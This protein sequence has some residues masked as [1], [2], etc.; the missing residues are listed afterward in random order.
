LSN[1][2]Q[3]AANTSK[4]RLETAMG[5]LAASQRREAKVGLGGGALNGAA[6]KA[7]DDARAAVEEASD[8][9]REAKR[10]VSLATTT[11]TFKRLVSAFVALQTLPEAAGMLPAAKQRAQQQE[12]LQDQD[13]AMD[14]LREQD[15]QLFGAATSSTASS[16]TASSPAIAA[17]RT[18]NGASPP[19]APDVALSDGSRQIQQP[20][21]QHTS[22]PL[23]AAQAQKSR[24]VQP[25]AAEQVTQLP[26]AERTQ[27]PDSQPQHGL[28]NSFTR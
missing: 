10:R 16:S 3:A 8:A 24:R 27:S 18:A 9:L 23:D 15:Q 2:V 13:V 28:G 22:Q 26:A 14:E 7:A 25:S 5:K 11:S 20:T 1:C 17:S 12:A 6:M 21:S 19:V 4:Q